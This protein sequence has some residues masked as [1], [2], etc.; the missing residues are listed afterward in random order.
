MRRGGG[1]GGARGGAPGRPLFLP[2]LTAKPKLVPFVPAPP[3]PP[4]PLVCVRS[5]VFSDQHA[6]LSTLRLVRDHARA[7]AAL[8]AA[9]PESPP[10]GG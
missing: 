10:A 1:G 7:L 2:S 8:P 5:S 9:A 4:P 3:P 6:D